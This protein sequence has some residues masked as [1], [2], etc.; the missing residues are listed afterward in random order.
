MEPM[1]RDEII[2]ALQ[3]ALE[4]EISAIEMYTIHGDTIQDAGIVQAVQAIR[5]VEK[6]HAK[7]LAERI[8]ALGEEPASK[9]QTATITSRSLAGTQDNTMDMLRLELAEEQNAIVDYA[10]AIARILEDE[11]T[12]DMLEE[13]LLDEIRHAR[14]LK[15]QICAL[16][17]TIQP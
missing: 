2:Q 7:A 14:W 6:G 11:T 1:T 15:S 13:H 4:A 16:D 3:K 10:K 8:H 12:L 17:K 5:D 9:T